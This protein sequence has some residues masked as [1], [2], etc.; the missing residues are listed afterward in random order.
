MAFDMRLKQWGKT[1]EINIRLL[2]VIGVT[3]IL[4]GKRN[5]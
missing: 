4:P 5:Y 2:K 1:L 3:S